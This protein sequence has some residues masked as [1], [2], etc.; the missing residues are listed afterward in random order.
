[1]RWPPVPLKIGSL[2]AEVTFLQSALALHGYYCR[3]NGMFGK[4]TEEKVIEFQ[5][6]NG[7]E[8]DGMVLSHVFWEKILA[9]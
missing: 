1:M 5:K 3:I 8:P 2:G 9:L 6:D 7:L 4:D